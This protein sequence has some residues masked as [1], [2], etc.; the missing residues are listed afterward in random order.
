MENVL[1]YIRWR[2]DL[3]FRQDP[4]NEVDALIFSSL[5]YVR[6]EGRAVEDPYT[7]ILLSEA[8]AEFFCLPDWKNRGRGNND[9]ELF[10]AAAASI[11]FG[12][13]K[14]VRYRS[15][16]VPEEDTQFAAETFLLDDGSMCIAFRGTDNTLV[17]WKEDFNMCFQQTVPSQRLAQEYVRELFSEYMHPMYLCGHSKGGNLAVFSGSR[18]SPMVQDW[19]FGV[20]NNDGPGF[21]DYMMGDPGYLAM[22]PRIH[23]FVPQSS[24]IGML[25]GREEPQYIVHSNQ[26]SIF[27]H[28]PYSWEVCGKAIVRA[29]ELTSDSRFIKATI[30]NWLL[31]MDM[32]ERNQMVEALF[33][34]LSYGNVERAGDIFNPKNLRNY[35]K[36]IGSN[37]SIRKTLS[38]EFDNLLEAAKKSMKSDSPPAMLQ[39]ST[40]AQTEEKA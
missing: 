31:K 33:A 30:E 3:T 26:V 8:A 20:Y 10:R 2:G 15:Q 28:D 9:L 6:L 25:M 5:A 34:L 19:I 16:F 22:V 29:P 7:P 38:E 27:Q 40:E 18:S 1:D 39:E 32:E 12:G 4:Y 35:I 11:R 14:L 24:I 13:A 36:L 37:E 17:G 23:T 21:T